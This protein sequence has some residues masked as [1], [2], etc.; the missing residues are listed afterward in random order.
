[1]AR[2]DDTTDR[3]V[4][5]YPVHKLPPAPDTGRPT[6][7]TTRLVTARP[8][9]IRAELGLHR[10]RPFRTPKRRRAARDAG[11]SLEAGGEA[12]MVGRPHAG[13][14]AVPGGGADELG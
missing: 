1:M 2:L 8:L 6:E 11:L 13:W 12:G 5:N 14:G 4:L 10:R 7:E 9:L 3:V